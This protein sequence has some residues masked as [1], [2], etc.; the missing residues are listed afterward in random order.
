MSADGLPARPPPI[1][2]RMTGASRAS[3]VPVTRGAKTLATAVLLIL[4]PFPFVVFFP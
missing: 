1:R 3:L 4:S 2:D